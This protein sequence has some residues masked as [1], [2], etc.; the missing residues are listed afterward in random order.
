MVSIHAL[1]VEL[2]RGIINVVETQQDLFNLALVSF[3]H[4]YAQERLYARPA[5]ATL[6]RAKKFHNTVNS[7]KVIASRVKAIMAGTGA[8]EEE[9]Q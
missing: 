5:I 3:F 1:P 9:V 8:F 7:S 4:S 6:D 2:V